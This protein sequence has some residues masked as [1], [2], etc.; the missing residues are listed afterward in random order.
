MIDNSNSRL[1]GVGGRLACFF[2]SNQGITYLGLL[3]FAVILLAEA[4][5]HEDAFI[6]LRTVDNFI[7]GYGLRYNIIERVQTFTHPLWMFALVIPYAIT[8]DPLISATFLSVVTSI[9]ALYLLLHYLTDTLTAKIA[10]LLIL[11]SSRPYIDY[12]TAGLENPMSHLLLVAFYAIYFTRSVSIRSLFYLALLASLAGVNRLDTLLLYIPPL[13]IYTLRVR[14][15]KAIKALFLGAMP[16]LAWTLFSL[17]YYG[18]P[19]P[20]SAYAK[21]N[22]HI[23]PVDLFIQGG[24]Y[25]KDLLLRDPMS[26]LTI[27]A[28]LLVTF[29]ERNRFR[30]AI[31]AGLILYLLYILRIGGDYMSGRFFTVPLLAATVLLVRTEWLNT[32]SRRSSLVLLGMIL[33][34]GF[35]SA[36]PVLLPIEN[37]RRTREERGITDE[38]LYY[39]S[40]TGL[41]ANLFGKASL[42]EQWMAR[43]GI[44]ARE[45]GESIMFRGGIGLAG[46][47]AGHQVQVVDSLA[48]SDVL[49]ARLPV[50]NPKYWRI[51]HFKRVN[52]A[53][54][55]DSKRS[56]ANELTDPQLA[57]FY[58]ILQGITQDPILDW[59][60]L[61]SIWKINMGQYDNLL[62]ADQYI[63]QQL[64]P[65]DPKS[66]CRED[67]DRPAIT[68][69]CV[70]DI[71]HQG[72][73]IDFHELQRAAA[74]EFALDA[75]YDYEFVFLHEDIE[76]GRL[77]DSTPGA[78]D[79]LVIR[80]IEV[81]EAVSLT[82]FDALYFRPKFIGLDPE[83][84]RVV[85]QVTLR[86]ET[87]TAPDQS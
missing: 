86:N 55:K 43:S 40:H 37:D 30:L 56:G 77:N 45:T 1:R 19:V 76:I 29:Y 41:L 4:W 15:R 44:D 11:I 79:E 50:G 65:L 54:F 25:Y 58:D 32:L 21:L 10:A 14:D 84:P 39:D 26:L 63:L 78:S 82:G 48:L 42:E 23:A 51:G 28:S 36:N 38:R 22:T 60:R 33:A 87:E 47:F 74:I 2:S 52:P 71:P 73:R 83:N 80:R 9:L 53:G 7:S 62:D 18:F 16:L 8:K 46:Y 5:L 68:D 67:V 69:Q 6:T 24:Y 57:M 81:P 13:I 20:N 75:N 59:Q 27:A 12:G 61:A 70:R 66:L 64:R 35:L 31:A 34:A 49:L 3:L 17:V 72:F 85:G